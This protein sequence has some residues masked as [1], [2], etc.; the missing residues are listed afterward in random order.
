MINSTEINPKELSDYISNLDKIHCSASVVGDE[1]RVR[2][3]PMKDDK[4]DNETIKDKGIFYI[5]MYPDENLS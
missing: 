5:R 1:I 2:L 3:T 4:V